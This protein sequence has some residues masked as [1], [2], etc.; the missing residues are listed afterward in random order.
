MP[1]QAVR[2]VAGSWTSSDSLLASGPD[3]GLRQADAGPEV[4]PPPVGAV[5]DYPAERIRKVKE[6]QGAERIH[7]PKQKRKLVG[8]GR[9]REG[10]D[11]KLLAEGEDEDWCTLSLIMAG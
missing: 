7:A 1:G 3:D 5:L 6:G 4:E 11:I 9:V 8:T 10:K 2:I